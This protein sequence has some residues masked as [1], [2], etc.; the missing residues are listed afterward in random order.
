MKIDI[1]YANYTDALNKLRADGSMLMNFKNDKNFNEILEHVDFDFGNQYKDQI[2]KEFGCNI[3][4]YINLISIN[5]NIG[6]PQKFKFEGIDMSP[7]NLRYIYHALLIQSKCKNWFRKQK[8][9]IVEIGGGYGGL[10]FYIKNILKD[11]NVNYTIIDLPEPGYLQDQ[12][13]KKVGDNN[14]RT[15]SCFDIDSVSS[16]KFDLVISNYCLSE[17]SIDNQK[18]Y[19]EKIVK[20]CEKKFFVWNYLTIGSNSLIWKYL[21]IRKFLSLFGIYPKIN[22]IN[23]KDYI[24]E[25]ERPK[26]SG[27]NQFIYSK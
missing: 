20:N 3:K 9:K 8:I 24:F 18:D 19:F 14:V 1:L 7:S 26:N 27:M 21:K 15:I 23:K 11:Y 6:N 13:S 4:N 22:Y 5:D 16:E 10:C 12:Y 25:D 2:Y 17:V